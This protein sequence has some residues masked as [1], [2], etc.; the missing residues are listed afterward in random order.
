[1]NRVLMQS[2]CADGDN[3]SEI[4]ITRSMYWRRASIQDGQVFTSVI[5][6]ILA[7][8]NGVRC[9]NFWQIWQQISPTRCR[10]PGMQVFLLT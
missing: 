8:F 6:G 4:I 1:V 9:F 5:G 7:V 3:G 10:I 2:I